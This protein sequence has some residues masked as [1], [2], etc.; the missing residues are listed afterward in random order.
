MTVVTDRATGGAQATLERACQ[1]LLALQDP[2]GFW[3][4]RARNER[5]DRRRGPVPRPLP[6]A[7]ASPGQRRADGTL[8]SQPST[9]RRLMGDL[10][11]GAGRPFHEGRGVRRATARGRR[12]GCRAH[13]PRSRVHPRRGR[14][15]VDAGLH[16]DVAGASR[17]LVV[18]GGAAL[19]PE[20]ILLPARAPLSVYAFGCWA[21]QTIV[22]LS[23]V[24]ALQPSVSV[25]FGIKE[26]ETGTAPRRAPDDL[27]GRVFLLVD[28]IAHLYG[29]HPV[30]PLRRAAL[31]RAERWIVDRQERDGSWGGIQP[32]WVWSIVALH[33]R[34]Y[35]RDHPG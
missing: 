31:R 26:L 14:G 10:L 5:D 13:A 3:E 7:R 24:T 1:R 27:W 25:D 18:G 12:R 2:E 16:P 4:G 21:R 19:P 8:D 30:P 23:V 35:D 9:R 11:R 22:A 29:R 33:A 32:P 34:G 28:R 20:Q 6:G 15:R 17:A